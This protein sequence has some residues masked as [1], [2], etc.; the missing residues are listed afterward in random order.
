MIYMKNNIFDFSDYKAYLKTLI[1][2]SPQLGHGFKS[3]IAKT[4]R[5]QTAYVSQ[6]LNQNANFSLEQAEELNLLLQH[7]KE[8]GRFLLL[9]IQKERAGSVR[10]RKRFE[11]DIAEIHSKRERLKE[12]IE[13]TATLST[14]NQMH[15][16]SRWYYSAIHIAC[17]IPELQTEKNCRH[18]I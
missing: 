7:T 14:E 11:E 9:L 4:L 15:Y 18:R 16:Y 8:E 12:R 6:V 3:K 10:L 5:C 17:T 13:K 2:T 1:R